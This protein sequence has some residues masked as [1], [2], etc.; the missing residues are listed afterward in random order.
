[1]YFIAWG[2][3]QHRPRGAALD[4]SRVYARGD[5][6]GV[7]AMLEQDHTHGSFITASKCRLLKL[8]REDFHRLEIA[9]PEIGSY[10]RRKAQER[11]EASAQAET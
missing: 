6:F 3:V 2:Q 11:R 4:A 9:C 10:L 5:F 1:M 8:H 7:V